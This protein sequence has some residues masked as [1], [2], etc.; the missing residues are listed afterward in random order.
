MLT[1][2]LGKTTKVD[3]VTIHGRGRDA[4][5]PTVLTG[6]EVDRLLKVTQ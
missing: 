4:G 5:P 6:V 2:G 3:R 1:F